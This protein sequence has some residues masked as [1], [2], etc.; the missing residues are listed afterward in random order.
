MAKCK[1]CGKDFKLRNR[2][3]IFCSN[4]KDGSGNCKSAYWIKH[5]DRKT[6][7]QGQ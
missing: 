6:K 1:Q 2:D 3:Q 4:Q 7:K 5:R